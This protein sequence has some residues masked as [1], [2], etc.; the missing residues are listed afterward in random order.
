MRQECINDDCLSSEFDNIYSKHAL[1]ILGTVFWDQESEGKVNNSVV[2]IILY[3]F[4][5]LIADNK[6]KVNED[7]NK[8]RYELSEIFVKKINEDEQLKSD[9]SEYGLMVVSTNT[10]SNSK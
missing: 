2:D 3:P 4:N 1:K 6:E 8:S 10:L 9:L 5:F 7:F